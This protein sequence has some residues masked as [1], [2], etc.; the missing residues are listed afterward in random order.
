MMR[1]VVTL[2][3]F[4]NLVNIQRARPLE[5]ETETTPS[6]FDDDLDFTTPSTDKGT[7]QSVTVAINIT[8]N[9]GNHCKFGQNFNK[10]IFA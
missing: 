5:N 9:L 6:P 7:L 2:V 3:I 10:S 8:S 4:S 1:S